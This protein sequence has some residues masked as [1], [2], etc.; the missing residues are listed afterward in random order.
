[1][2]PIKN[3]QPEEFTLKDCK[4]YLEHYP[5]GEHI[6]AVKKRKKSLEEGGADVIV[7]AQEQGQKIQQKTKSESHPKQVG[8]K[9]TTTKSDSTQSYKSS[10]YNESNNGLK[11]LGTIA[12]LAIIILCASNGERLFGASPFL[13]GGLF[14][15]YIWK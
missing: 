2:N 1:M 13:A 12:V 10:T 3:K 5:Y 7:K 9:D 8:K 6:I 14:I 4:Y 11:I 15:Y